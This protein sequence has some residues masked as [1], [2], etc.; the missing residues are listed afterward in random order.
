MLTG[1]LFSLAFANPPESRQEQ[2]DPW[3][4]P[5]GQW[6]PVFPYTGYVA[7]WCVIGHCVGIMAAH[8]VSLGI[9][10]LTSHTTH[11]SHPTRPHPAT[12]PTHPLKN[13]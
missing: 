5:I 2:L 4:A 13:R 11:P 8:G 7:H 12:Y 1:L 10:F 3:R 9:I 6:G